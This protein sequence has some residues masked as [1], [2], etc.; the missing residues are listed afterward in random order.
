MFNFTNY[1]DIRYHYFHVYVPGKH[2]EF[3]LNLTK[4]PGVA[5]SFFIEEFLRE[6]ADFIHRNLSHWYYSFYLSIVYIV[7]ILLLRKWMEHRQPFQMKP[8]LIVW[9][10]GLAIF[11]II[12]TFRCL[13]EFIH[14][15]HHH[16]LA[17]S[18]SKSTYYFDYR[19]SAWY[20]MFTLSKSI[21]LFDTAFVLMRKKPLIA[22]HWIHHLLTLNYSWF[23]FSDAPA[24]ARWMC[25]MNYFVHSLMYSYYALKVAGFQVPR[26][27][28]LTITTLQI[29]Q[30]FAGLF[31][32]CKALQRKLLG[33][34]CDASL[35]VLITGVTLYGLF[36]VLFINFFIWTYIIKGSRQ[37]IQSAVRHFTNGKTKTTTTVTKTTTTTNGSI[38]FVAKKVQ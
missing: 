2:H 14:V 17:H 4:F 36:A 31:V 32:N 18:Y 12:G 3:E 6:N 25:N 33:L 34:P 24:T 23:V 30:M 9:N 35:S 29:A 16:G 21:E 1:R 27:I 22:L 15:L 7:A 11:S 10:F 8:I 28:S 20:L 37:K 26:R 19:L 5:N 13:P 38:Q